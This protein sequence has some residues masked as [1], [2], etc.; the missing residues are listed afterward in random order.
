MNKDRQICTVIFYRYNIPW[1]ISPHSQTEHRYYIIV[2]NQ[3]YN[4][5]SKPQ[6]GNVSK[7]TLP[8]LQSTAIDRIF[9]VPVSQK[10]K[11]LIKMI[12]IKLNVSTVHT[13]DRLSNI[14]DVPMMYHSLLMSLLFYIDISFQYKTITLFYNTYTLIKSFFNIVF[15]YCYW[16]TSQKRNIKATETIVTSFNFYLGLSIYVNFDYLTKQ[17]IILSFI[18]AL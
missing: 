7:I 1:F 10:T 9:F 16:I 4:T 2:I 8:I 13:I 18:N 11:F 12:A 3:Q 6:Q 17:F 15:Q 14:V 5:Q